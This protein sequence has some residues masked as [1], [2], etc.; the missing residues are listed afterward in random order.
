[1]YASLINLYFYRNEDINNVMH[2]NVNVECRLM[3]VGVMYVTNTNLQRVF[4][5]S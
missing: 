1:M 2:C 4:T 3:Y 5:E